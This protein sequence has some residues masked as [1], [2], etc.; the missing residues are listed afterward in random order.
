M[1]KHK[2][3]DKMFLDIAQRIS[4]QSNCV[5]YHVGAVLVKSNRIISTGYNGSPPGFINCNEKFIGEFNR[6]DH[7]EWSNLF[8]VHAEMNS[9]LFASKEG[10]ETS[11]TTLYCTHQPCH[12]CLKHLIAAGIIRVIYERPYD[13]SGYTKETDELLKI[14]GI[15]FE[16]F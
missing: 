9:I 13:K 5:S 11:N 1:D 12:N 10:K 3:I 7:H 8:E 2:K 16:I 4:E 15:K 14:S 6:E